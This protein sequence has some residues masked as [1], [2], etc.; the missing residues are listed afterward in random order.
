MKYL[1]KSYNCHFKLSKNYYP[2]YYMYR[3]ADEN[4]KI[5]NVSHQIINQVNYKIQEYLRVPIL[6]GDFNQDI[7]NHI[8]NNIKD[9]ILEFKNQMETAADENAVALEKEGKPVTPFRISNNYAVTYNKNNLVSI[10]LIYHQYI[11]GRN[12]YIRTSYNYN[13]ENARSM[14][15]KDLFKP[16]SDYISVL[17]SKIKY[18]L[19][20]NPEEYDLNTITNFKGIAEDQ[21]YYLDNNNLVLFFG[22]NEISPTSSGIPLVK[23]PFSELSDILNPQLLKSV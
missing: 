6:S 12:S 5:L 4:T 13:L 22:F 14:P 11:N 17:N 21:P 8:N 9:D 3:N 7:L 20:Q 16:E 23:I 19:Q 10:S 18:I 15:L 1:N 2:Q